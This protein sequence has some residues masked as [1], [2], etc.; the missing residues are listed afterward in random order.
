MGGL[1]SKCG[2]G[3][4]GPVCGVCSLGYFKQFQACTR[5]PSKKWITGQLSIFAAILVIIVALLVWKS[6]KRRKEKDRE[7]SL[8]DTFF[9]KLKI[10]IGFYQVTHGLL[11]AFSYIQW[12]GSLQVISK[13]SG[14]LQ[15]NLLQIAPV[16]CLFPGLRVDAF[17][18]LCL[19]MAMNIT[20]IGA[21]GIVYC[22]RKMIISRRQDLGAEEKSYKISQ[23]KEIV[24]KNLFFLLYVT[25]LS[26]CSKTAS[27]LPF[28]CRKLCKDENEEPCS[29]YLKADYSI[30]CQGP[31]YNN[32]LI[33]AYISTAYIF[34]LPTASFIALWRYRREILTA[35]DSEAVTSTEM[36]A[37]LRFLFENYNTR[38]WFWELVEMSRKVTLTT[39]L[40]LVGQESRSYIGLA[41][42]VA[43]MYGM[44]FCWV[45]PTQDAFENKLM[46]TSLAV[47]V[48][49]LGIGAVSRIPAENI[50]DSIDRYTDAVIMK[51]LIVGANS[52]VIGL[53]VVQYLVYLYQYLNEWRKN[54]HWSFSCCLAL[55]LPLNDLQGEIRGMAG[56]NV[57]KTQLQ[58]GGVEKPSIFSS[59]KDSGAMDITLATVENKPYD[60]NKKELNET[61]CRFDKC[62]RGT[63]TKTFTLPIAVHGS[64]KGNQNQY[65]SQRSKLQTSDEIG[66]TELAE[67]M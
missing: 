37:G 4:E 8:K 61:K 15:M 47:T 57:L 62:H 64:L 5:C 6:K 16:H 27:V 17:G 31:E 7:R 20:V 48:V 32:L 13:Y 33:V 51:I 14:I 12:P 2:N 65:V 45:K 53:L 36:I 42:V 49:N 50:P 46:S 58:T 9:S 59:A 44:L 34:A 24:Y 54:P 28:A 41:W 25:Y 43:G 11:E 60:E 22:V 63:Q 26:T 39:G 40:I 67:N 1:D 66:I 56:K 19:M 55:L 18:D 21:S 30:R 10:V 23:T 38:S 3:Y 29:A 35:I 52:L